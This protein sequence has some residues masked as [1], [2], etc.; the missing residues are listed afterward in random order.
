M[1]ATKPEASTSLW[2]EGPLSRPTCIRC[3]SGPA[4]HR[5]FKLEPQQRLFA[6]RGDVDYPTI[7][8]LSTAHD[9][10]LRPSCG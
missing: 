8:L 10:S 1:P 2:P 6:V 4:T 9:E 7:L 3:W 5:A